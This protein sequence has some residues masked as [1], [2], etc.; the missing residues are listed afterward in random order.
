MTAQQNKAIVRDFG[1]LAFNQRQP[2]QA[3]AKSVGAARQ[4]MMQSN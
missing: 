4:P 2:E 1:D 3:A